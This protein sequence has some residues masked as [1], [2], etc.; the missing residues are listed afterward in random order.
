[1]I[2]TK[3][4]PLVLLPHI[5]NQSQPEMGSEDGDPFEQNDEEEDYEDDLPAS[6]VS[7]SRD[8]KRI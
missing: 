8:S 6:Q 1:V 7:R 2:E 3:Y 5:L 4:I